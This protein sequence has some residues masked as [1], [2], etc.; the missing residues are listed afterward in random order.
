MPQEGAPGVRVVVADDSAVMRRLIGDALRVPGSIEVVAEAADGDE[1]LAACEMHAPDV[2]TLDLSM[3][4][5]NGL[6]V[7]DRLRAAR[8]RVRVVVVSAFSPTLV[9]RALDVLDAGATDLVAKPK[10]GES[11]HDFTQQVR[12]T[13]LAAA[14]SAPSAPARPSSSRI[15]P[16]RPTRTA[17]NSGRVL[18]IASSTGGP[19]AL[20]EL[21]P[22]LGTRIGIG[23]TI[24]QHMPEGFT[25]PLARR[26]DAAASVAVREAVDGDRLAG[27][28]ILVAPAGRHLRFDADGT[29]RLESSDPV[30]GLRPRADLT[31]RDLVGV[32][33]A[34]VVLVVL[35]G[36]G[37]DALDGAK[38]V[39]E[40]GG[41][42]LAQDESDCVVY[43]MPRHVV[44]HDLADA[45]GTIVELPTL[46]E[47]AL[48]TPFPAR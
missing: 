31:I 27:D 4:R 21:V 22:A 44:E 14:P 18:V 34:R 2:L 17:T 9:E 39:R 19:R 35:T 15:A 36:M 10:A 43:G 38:A 33:G 48:G 46:V 13:V 45:T 42:V 41:I 26:L 47:R 23:A 20:S 6:E 28:A 29:A 5:T 8:S 32:H 30:G 24:V 3:P 7:L 12:R 1:A 25:A 37:S 11:F 40:A 16:P